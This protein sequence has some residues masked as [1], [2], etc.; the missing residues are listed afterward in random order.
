MVFPL[1]TVGQVPNERMCF[2]VVHYAG[3]V[4]Y[5]V[6][7]FLEKN[8]DTIHDDVKKMLKKST[9]GFVSGLFEAGGEEDAGDAKSKVNKTPHC[10]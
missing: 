1:R 10:S 5:D 8:K 9:V 6:T 3:V 2:G 4:Y 7:N